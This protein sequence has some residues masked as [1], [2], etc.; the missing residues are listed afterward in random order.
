MRC[1][2]EKEKEKE[3]R[4]ILTIKETDFKSDLK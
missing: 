2:K 1:L 4:I 3:K